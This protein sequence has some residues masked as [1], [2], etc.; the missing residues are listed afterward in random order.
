MVQ[1][2]CRSF[3]HYRSIYIFSC[4]VIAMA[5]MASLSPGMAAPKSAR[6]K[7]NRAVT[8]SRSSTAIRKAT[9]SQKKSTAV[10]KVKTSSVKEKVAN[11]TNNSAEL[12][13]KGNDYLLVKSYPEALNT[14]KVLIAKYPHLWEGYRIAARA[15]YFLDRPTESESYLKK[16]ILKAPQEQRARLSK[17]LDDIERLKTALNLRDE[18]ESLAKNGEMSLAAEKYLAATELMPERNGWAMTAADLY[19]KAGELT[20]AVEVLDGISMRSNGSVSEAAMA[21]SN[22][23]RARMVK[24]EAERQEQQAKA[25]IARQEQAKQEKERQRAAQLESDRVRAE[26]ARQQ[27][28]LQRK[29]EEDERKNRELNLLTLRLKD[30]QAAL[31]EIRSELSKAQEGLEDA[32]NKV[33]NAEYPAELAQSSY[34]RAEQR[35][36]DAQAKVR[37]SRDPITLAGNQILEIYAKNDYDKAKMELENANRKLQRARTSVRAA[38]DE[39]RGIQNRMRYAEQ[40]VNRIEDQIAAVR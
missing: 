15:S 21:R 39:V 28:E 7:S 23:L 12:I 13:K 30:K 35:Y 5:G 36:E 20:Q 26:Q 2:F 3:V 24:E 17:G 29:R 19:V 11:S 9:S 31:N 1:P 6:V 18:G 34:N 38:Q 8:K 22:R 4:S 16:A 37:N 25:E 27:Q 40:E 32:Q 14:A 33:E 10:N